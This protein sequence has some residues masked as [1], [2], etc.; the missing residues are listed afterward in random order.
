MRRHLPVKVETWLQ[1]DLGNRDA[2]A[3]EPLYFILDHSTQQD[4]AMGV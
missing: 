4:I 1:F 2:Y 3:S